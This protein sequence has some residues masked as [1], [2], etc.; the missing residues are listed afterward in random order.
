MTE[1]RDPEKIVREIKRKTRRKFSTEEKIRVVLDGLR[2]EDTIAE[3]VPSRGDFHLFVISP[4]GRRLL[5]NLVFFLPSHSPPPR[6][7]PRRPRLIEPAALRS[8]AERLVPVPN[9]I[10]LPLVDDH[11]NRHATAPDACRTA[12]RVCPGG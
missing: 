7:F 5:I 11:F 4:M 6:H 12:S 8:I 1:N 2:G 9:H 3:L 10:W